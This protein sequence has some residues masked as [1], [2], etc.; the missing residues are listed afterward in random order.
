ML[1]IGRVCFLEMCLFCVF[2][3]FIVYVS[4]VYVQDEY[5]Q[6]ATEQM[7]E[8]Q[9]LESQLQV[10]ETVMQRDVAECVTDMETT[11]HSAEVDLSG[12]HTCTLIHWLLRND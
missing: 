11:F 3:F 4:L 1:A 12:A 6:E 8:I 9:E 2:A 10:F 7:E 5:D